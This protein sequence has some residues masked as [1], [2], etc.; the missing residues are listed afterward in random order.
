MYG[1]SWSDEEVADLGLGWEAFH[2]RHGERSYK[3]W[4]NKRHQG[5]AEATPEPEFLD[6]R[7]P[8]S[9]EEAEAYYDKLIGLQEEKRAHTLEQTEVTI[10]LKTE[11]PVAVYFDGDWHGGNQGTDH[12]TLRIENS[13]IAGTPGTYLVGMGDYLHNAKAGM[14]KAGVALYDSAFPDPEDQKGFVL[15]ELQKFEGK[16]L[17][18]I[19][20]CHED[21]DYQL[22]GIRTL[23]D[24]CQKLGTANLWHGGLIRL[25]V[26]EVTYRF[27]VRHKARGESGINTTNVQRRLVDDW[28][29][30]EQPDVVCVAHLHYPDFEAKSRH[31]QEIFYMRSG[32]YFVW[33][34][35]GQ[36]LGGYRGKIGVPSAILFP[37]RKRMIGFPGERLAESL[38]LLNRIRGRVPDVAPEVVTS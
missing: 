32:S 7:E 29:W 33:D 8:M 5:S 2:Q 23:R 21:W 4:W 36:K 9:R 18:L 20:G 11:Y 13:L 14:G 19:R 31:G 3:A 34:E 1:R 17:A 38:D 30:L 16:I 28:P 10:R 26:G 6:K 37:D 12:R 24:V 15:H 35:F 25:Q 22:A 27:A